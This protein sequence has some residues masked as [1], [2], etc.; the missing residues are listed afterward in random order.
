MKDDASASSTRRLA[1]LVHGVPVSIGPWNLYAGRHLA[2]L[3]IIKSHVGLATAPQQSQSEF[4][5]GFFVQ[6]PGQEHSARTFL[7]LPST[8]N[9]RTTKPQTNARPKSE[10]CRTLHEYTLP[11]DEEG[12][13]K[14]KKKKQAEHDVEYPIFWLPDFK[15]NHVH[16]K[17][18]TMDLEAQQCRNFRSRNKQK[19]D[20]LRHL[21]HQLYGS[22]G[23]EQVQIAM[24]AILHEA[25]QQAIYFPRARD[26]KM[27]IMRHP[28]ALH[29]PYSV[30]NDQEKWW[31]IVLNWRPH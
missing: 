28:E 21:I 18:K 2:P 12:K 10:T 25:T 16:K 4:Q 23:V 15:Q 3:A 9:A 17:R 7:D 31:E 29:Q 1:P 8:S 22:M 14:K 24:E 20:R 11:L 13:K 27:H 30:E 26:M 19:R 6:T 5:R